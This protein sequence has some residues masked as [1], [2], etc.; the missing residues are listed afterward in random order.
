MNRHRSNWSAMGGSRFEF[1][2]TLDQ[3]AEERNKVY[4]QF[5]SELKESFEQLVK[6]HSAMSDTVHIDSLI[7]YGLK[8]LITNYR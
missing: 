7:D 4:N 3:R 2:D 5:E 1:E 6:K 8:I